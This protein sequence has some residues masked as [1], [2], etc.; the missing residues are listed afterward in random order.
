MIWV[1]RSRPNTSRAMARAST[2]PLAAPAACS[3]R[4]RISIS[5]RP[6]AAQISPPAT[7]SAMPPT[8]TG[9]RPSPSDSDPI[10]SVTAARVNRAMLKVNCAVAGDTAKAAPTAG[11]AGR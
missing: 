9:R 1:R 2:S 6:A 5:I 10:A 3:S 11:K 7:N 8:S 4:P